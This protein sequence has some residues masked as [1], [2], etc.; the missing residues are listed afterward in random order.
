[1]TSTLWSMRDRRAEHAS[2]QST[3]KGAVRRGRALGTRVAR[4]EQV[5]G[6]V[7]IQCPPSKAL[8]L[9]GDLKRGALSR[10]DL[11]VVHIGSV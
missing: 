11:H 9:A 2:R 1:M 10:V 3:G 8:N 5:S 4:G 6:R 7:D